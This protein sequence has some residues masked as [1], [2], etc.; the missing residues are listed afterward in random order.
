LEN[1]TGK[2]GEI[3]WMGCKGKIACVVL[4]GL[5]LCIGGLTA[6]Q[7]EN[8]GAALNA[9]R[10][11]QE[12]LE[13]KLAENDQTIKDAINKVPEISIREVTEEERAALRD[14][15]LTQEE[16]TQ[17]LIQKPE[18]KPE[19]KPEQPSKPKTEP[20]NK[21]EQKPQPQTPDQSTQQ[22]PPDPAVSV[23]PEPEP[24]PE[25]Q[26]SEYEQ[27]INA[28]IAE[29][30]VLREEF[31]IK[32][33]NMQAAAIADYRAIPADQRDTKTLMNLASG[34]I[35]KGLDLEKQ[36]DAR[37]EAI[38]VE[39]EEI[40]QKNNGDLSIAQTVYDTYVQEKGLKKAWYMAELKKM[41]MI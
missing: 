30:F 9:V 41:G 13:E 10:F 23:T 29:V 14:G 33:D 15:T 16:L 4:G 28:L 40:L 26:P 36:C 6:W 2:Q 19:P 22:T 35:S 5:L 31:L 25:P 17:S 3:G 20:Q 27:Q 24:E 18:S 8:I 21:P 12:E 34:Y 32:L 7:W 37:I 39:L 1:S 38:V 11:S